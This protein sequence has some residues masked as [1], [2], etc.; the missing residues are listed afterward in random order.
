MRKRSW[1]IDTAEILDWVK[2]DDWHKDA[3]AD[4]TNI[5]GQDAYQSAFDA[6]VNSIPES[7]ESVVSPSSF[8]FQ[9]FG[10]NQFQTDTTDYQFH[11]YGD[12]VVVEQFLIDDP[13]IVIN[14]VELTHEQYNLIQDNGGNALTLIGTLL[15]E[16]L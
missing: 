14:Q 2:W 3:F 4:D 13:D 16:V 1:N 15:T 7:V 6:L 11:W 8:N 10:W 12:N 9:E 5:T